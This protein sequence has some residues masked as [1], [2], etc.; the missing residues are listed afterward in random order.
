MRKKAS[1]DI[2]TYLSV[3]EVL[4]HIIAVTTL[5]LGPEEVPEKTEPVQQ[6]RGLK[7]FIGKARSRKII[8][9]LDLLAILSISHHRIAI[10]TIHVAIAP[11]SRTSLRAIVGVD[12]NGLVLYEC[13][14]TVVVA[15]FQEVIVDIGVE[16]VDHHLG[17]IHVH[18]AIVTGSRGAVVHHGDTAHRA[19]NPGVHANIHLV[20]G[21]E[22]WVCSHP[23]LCTVEQF[24][25]KQFVLAN[26]HPPTQAT[27]PNAGGGGGGRLQRVEGGCQG[28]EAVSASSMTTRAVAF[29]F[30]YNTRVRSNCASSLSPISFKV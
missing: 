24:K 23:C 11:A 14:R 7:T 13:T 26:A 29:R 22:R 27:R 16:V 12:L 19:S 18:A 2:A 4:P 25:L 10:D 28:G 21:G 1:H 3:L 15:A 8:G 17:I 20:H 6:E 30:G 5:P 9:D